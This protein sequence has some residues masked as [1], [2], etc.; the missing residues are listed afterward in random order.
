M[1]GFLVVLSN[2]SRMFV[3]SNRFFSEPG[4]PPDGAKTC[5]GLPGDVFGEVLDL[6]WRT[7]Q[8]RKP[9]R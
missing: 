4:R 8:A 2:M 6:S 5:P 7:S 1:L 3:D 9:E